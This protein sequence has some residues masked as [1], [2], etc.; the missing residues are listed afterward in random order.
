MRGH[1]VVCDGCER[2]FHLACTGMRG[3]HALNFEDWVCGDCFSSGVKSKRWPL[4]VKS[5][6]LLDINASPPSDGDAYGEDG[7]ELPGFRYGV[8]WV[9]RGIEGVVTFGSLLVLATAV[10]FWSTSFEFP[11]LHE[12]FELGSFHV[13]EI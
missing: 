4:G 9:K 3:A 6:Q 12:N 2:G 13:R 10:I 7:E 8:L 5:K 1:V 11:L